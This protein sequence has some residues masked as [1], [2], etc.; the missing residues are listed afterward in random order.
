[1]RFRYFCLIVDEFDLSFYTGLN[2]QFPSSLWPLKTFQFMSYVKPV[3]MSSCLWKCLAHCR[4]SRI[5][6]HEHLLMGSDIYLI[7]AQEGRQRFWKRYNSSR[8]SCQESVY[9][10]PCSSAQSCPHCA[11]YESWGPVPSYTSTSSALHLRRY[12]NFPPISWTQ[13]DVRTP[14]SSW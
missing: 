9:N 13:Q 6:L 1:M 11:P 4:C 2:Q 8:T 14:R 3:L 12:C 10:Q 7:F 5:C